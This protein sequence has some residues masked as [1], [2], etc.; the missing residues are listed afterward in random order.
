MDFS[1][2]QTQEELSALARRILTDKE[3]PDRLAELDR[4]G[5]GFDERLWPELAA[6]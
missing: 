1:I 6:A 3:T 2:T 5:E 4:A